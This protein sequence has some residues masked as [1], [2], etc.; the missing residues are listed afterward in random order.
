MRPAALVG[1]GVFLV[2]LLAVLFTVNQLTLERR[3][4]IGILES[5]TNGPFYTLPSPV[6][7]GKPGTIVRKERINSGPNG[8]TTWRILYHSR[9]L[10]GKD[11]IV[12]GIVIS[13]DG[14]APAGGRTIVS[15]AHPTTGVA[16]RC[17]PSVGVD[18]Y[19]LIEGI[20]TLLKQGYVVAATD[21]P[22]MGAPGTNA[23]LV[24][25]TAGNSVLDAA[26]AAREL[27]P[28]TTSSDL[29]LWGHSQ[30]GQAALF[31]AQDA[32]T[33][34]PELKLKAVAVA[35]PATDLA[36]LLD[37]DIDDVSG[38][39]I[40][41]YAFDAYSRI[42]GADLSA[43]LTPAGVKALPGM[44]GLCLI[45]QNA[46]LHTIARPL[47]GH[48]LSADPTVTEPW[49]SLLAANTPD[50]AQL[51]VPLFIAQGDDDMLVRPSSTRDFA[52]HECALGTNVTYLA[53]PKTGHGTVALKAAPLL[54]GWF[55]DAT[56]G[57]VHSTGCTP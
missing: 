3:A 47:V 15:W 49:A 1:V 18:P 44:V 29:L 46:A 48:Y 34:A 43:I 42:Y 9:D 55:A 39:T 53:L 11:E 51:P 41:S 54:P 32:A 21:Y 33:Y 4:V 8:T 20:G 7:V 23:Y 50:A 24:G 14:A 5:V 31:A 26:R 25:K 37:D 40:G 56:A 2:A 28:K 30:G 19:S 57:K 12:S 17:A 13:P 16:Q 45:G 6:P 10:N 36:V 52:D 38:V 22:G 35:A 27:F